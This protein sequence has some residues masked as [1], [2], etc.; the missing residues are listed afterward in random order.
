MPQKAKVKETGEV[1]QLWRLNGEEIQR[2]EDGGQTLICPDPNCRGVMHLRAVDSWIQTH[3]AHNPGSG[4]ADCPNRV[5]ESAEHKLAKKKIAA[6]LQEKYPDAMVE[7]EYRIEGTTYA[8][9]RSID[10]AVI[11]ADGRKEAHEA[12][13]SYQTTKR[14]RQ[15]TQDY[16]DAGFDNVVWWLSG[17]ARKF[18]YREW[19]VDNCKQY[20]LVKFRHDTIMGVRTL[21]DAELQLIDSA[22]QRQQWDKRRRAKYERMRIAEERR[23]QIL[24]RRRTNIESRQNQV[25]D[26]PEP[27][28]KFE[29][30]G[31]P[32]LMRIPPA[33][34]II[35]TAAARANWRKSPSVA[36]ILVP[37]Y[38]RRLDED[39]KKNEDILDW[40]LELFR[41]GI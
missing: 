32:E 22:W 19:C 20:G 11:H 16:T 34:P 13:L 26:R 37:V 10:V 12:Q 4:L 27:A 38:E 24:E 6:F 17:R 30:L 21:V 41:N 39:S 33:E 14:F 1:I 15:R 7:V 36:A 2:L 28:A 23:A 29:P 18:A 9:S 31:T 5:S 3:F 40:F 35:T 8:K 25:G